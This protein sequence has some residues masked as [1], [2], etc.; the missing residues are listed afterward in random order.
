MMIKAISNESNAEGPEM[1]ITT[2]GVMMNMPKGI[3]STEAATHISSFMFVM[4]AIQGCN[5]A[6]GHPVSKT[7]LIL[8]FSYYIIDVLA[9]KEECSQLIHP[10]PI[11]KGK[12]ILIVILLHQ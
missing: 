6:I 4:F 9:L 1:F 12:G 2:Y 8:H 10:C 11:R 3:V 7:G 5:P